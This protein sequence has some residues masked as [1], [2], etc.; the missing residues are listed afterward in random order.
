MIFT[1][2]EIHLAAVNAAIARSGTT[3]LRV[4]ALSRDRETALGDGELMLVDNVIDQ[5][6]ATMKLKAVFANP[7]RRLWPGQSAP[8]GWI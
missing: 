8:R 3:R 4:T 7:E 1:L 6:T 5:S 2:P